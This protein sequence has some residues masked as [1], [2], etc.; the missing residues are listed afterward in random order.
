MPMTGRA[1]RSVDGRD[2][3]R[4]RRPIS[5]ESHLSIKK[6]GPQGTGFLAYF[7]GC[8]IL[9]SHRIGLRRL[10]DRVPHPEQRHPGTQ[11]A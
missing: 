5:T 6:A 11:G 8:G 1:P 7:H 10:Y 3:Y 2:M 4:G 9:Q